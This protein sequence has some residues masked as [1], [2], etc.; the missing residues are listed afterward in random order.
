MLASELLGSAEIYMSTAECA[1]CLDREKAPGG[2]IEHR[3]V[4][5]YGNRKALVATQVKRI[6]GGHTVKLDK[7]RDPFKARGSGLMQERDK[8][9]EEQEQLRTERDNMFSRYPDVLSSARRL[10]RASTL[11][12]DSSEELVYK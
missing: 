9:L 5:R 3:T 6:R 12:K 11:G 7:L 2:G 1:T 10:V 4:E 8:G